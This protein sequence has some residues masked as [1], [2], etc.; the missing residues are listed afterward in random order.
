[1]FEF[2]RFMAEYIPLGTTPYSTLIFVEQTISPTQLLD[3]SRKL[4]IYKTFRRCAGLLLNPFQEN[5][6]FLCPLKTSENLWSS[7][8]FRRYR[9]GTLA[10]MG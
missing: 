2:I 8:V 3:T 7:D 10:E 9:K 4:N 1:M 6:L 5:A